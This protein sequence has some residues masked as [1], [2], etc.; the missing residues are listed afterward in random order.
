[1]TTISKGGKEVLQSVKRIRVSVGTAGVLGLLRL[2]SNAEPTTAYLMTYTSDSCRANC[3]FCPQARGSS[4]N[5]DMLSRVVWPD[6]EFG[7]FMEKAVS[8]IREGKFCR[9]CIQALNYPDFIE[10][11]SQISSSILSHVSI[12]IS[13]SCPP[14]GKLEMERL[15]Q[16]GVDR[17]GLPID[18]A[19]PEIFDK[20]KGVLAGG[21]YHWE[22]HFSAVR[23]AL[24]VFGRNRVSTHLI[25]GLG[26]TERQMVEVVQKLCDMAVNPSLFALT[27]IKG[28]KLETS[29][30]PDIGQYRRV[31]VA[32]YLIM[33]GLSSSQL[34]KFDGSGKIVDFGTTPEV[35]HQTVS[36]G[37]P[38]KT[39]GCPGCNRPFYT[40][41]PRG[42]I[43][44]YP[45][46]LNEGERTRS[47]QEME[48]SD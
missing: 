2:H 29:K 33:Q 18:A 46:D 45:R 35:L 31:Q 20:V 27:P 21:P 16:I 41:S 12:P 14:T 42:P 17:I 39:L 32:R 37:Y 10:D 24:E 40:E 9:L 43:Y 8:S 3:S 30:R 28:T 23:S 4:S 48:I 15:K 13:V 38:F 19:T 25:V 5:K 22:S 36:R 47:L 34:M 11:I 7:V 26:E 44:N 1:M 6:F